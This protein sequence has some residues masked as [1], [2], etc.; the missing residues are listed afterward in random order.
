MFIN[1][2]KNWILPYSCLLCNNASDEDRDLCGACASE[3]PWLQQACDRCGISLP[4][5]QTCGDCLTHT[6]PYNRTLALWSYEQP[7]DHFITQFKFQHRLVFSRL[8]ASMLIQKI[9]KEYEVSDLP[10]YI[11]PVPLHPDRLKERG[12]NQALEIA[13]PIAAQLKLKIDT[14]HCVRSK[15]TAAQSTLLTTDDRRK[16]IKNA[17]TVNPLFQTKHVAIIDDV[18]TTGHTVREL[19]KS[20]KQIGIQKIDIWCC[21]RTA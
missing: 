7:I 4:E 8:L 12:F 15:A 9:Q 5:N 14:T 16:N 19:S 6:P 18:V 21:A 13:K 11:I 10:E 2:L 3:L 17:F 20:L 1:Q